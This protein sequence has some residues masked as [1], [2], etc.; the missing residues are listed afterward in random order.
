QIVADAIARIC[1]GQSREVADQYNIDRD[2]E[3]MLR[4]M[5]GKTAELFAACCRIG[6]ICAGRTPEENDALAAYGEQF[7]MAF[8]L[9]DD[10]LDLVSSEELLGKPVGNDV[11]EGVYTMPI[12]LALHG[13]TQET[14]R[15]ALSEHHHQ[16]A[17]LVELLI[18][19]YAIGKTIDVAR[20]F[21]AHATET[22]APYAGTDNDLQSLLTFPGQYLTW[23]LN[24]LVAP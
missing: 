24:N 22:L 17:Q 13:S 1:D 18:D 19:E 10:V 7:G 14:I 16:T 20:Q 23:S 9:I 21:T 15:Q 12:L 2:G 8:Q 4:S 5:R 3:L 11:A 6:G